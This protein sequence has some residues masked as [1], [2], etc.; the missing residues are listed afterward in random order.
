[1]LFILGLILLTAGTPLVLFGGFRL[2]ADVVVS[3]RGAGRA[4]LALFG[5]FPIAVGVRYVL[6]RLGWDIEEVT[7]VAYWIVFGVCVLACLVLLAAGRENPPSSG[8]QD[9][10]DF[11]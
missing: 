8:P 7:T 3:S 4:G 6:E 10:A 1:M 9:S 2:G 5:F 11:H